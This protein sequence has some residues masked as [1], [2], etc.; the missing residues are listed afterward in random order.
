MGKDR[1][2]ALP[3]VQEP[4]PEE[5]ALGGPIEYPPEHVLFKQGQP[6]RTLYYTV[7]GAVRLT[8]ASPVGTDVLLGIRRAGWLLGVGAAVL[9]VG[10]WATAVAMKGCVVRPVSMETFHARSLASP[11]VARWVA[12]AL[13]FDVRAHADTIAAHGGNSSERLEWYFAD[14]ARTAAVARPDGSLWIADTPTH[15]VLAQAIGAR[16]EYVG[17]LVQGLRS[18]GTLRCHKGRYSIPR[19]SR[20]FDLI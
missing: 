2:P 7:G 17:R 6:V 19:G 5:D 12:R 18:D 16:R 3:P 1:T 20:L 15:E 10:Y 8:V 13:A 11:A 9:E 4:W 14:L